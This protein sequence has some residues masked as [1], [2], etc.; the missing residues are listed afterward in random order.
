MKPRI[1]LRTVLLATAIVALTLG[2]AADMRRLQD[3]FRGQESRLIRDILKLKVDL[4]RSETAAQI[5]IAQLKAA[6][7]AERQK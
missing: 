2:W 6:L 7:K 1:S 3:Q 5:G 4:V